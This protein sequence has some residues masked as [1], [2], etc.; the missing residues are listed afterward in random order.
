[1]KRNKCWFLAWM[2]AFALLISGFSPMGAEAAKKDGSKAD[3]V[4]DVTEYGAEANAGTDSAPAIEKAVKAAKEASDKG[5]SVVINFPKGRYDI[6]PDKIKERELYVSNTVG[7]EQAYSKKKIGILLEKMNNVTVEGNGSLFMYH[8]KMTTFAAINCKNVTFQNFAVDFQTPTVVDVT[9]EKREGNSV[10]VYVPE[11]YNYEI[12]GNNVKWISDKSPY[13]G[14]PYWTDTGKMDYTQRFDTKTGLTWR[15]DT[16]KNHLFDGS[17]SKIEDVGNHRLKFTFSGTPHEELQPGFCYQ[18]R[19]TKRDHPG[20]FLWKSTDVTLRHLDIQFLHGFGMVGQ[21]SDTI[22]LDDVDFEAPIESG[23]TTAGYADFVQMSGCKGE[24]DIHDCTF[25]NPHDDPINV[26]GTFNEVVEVKNGGKTFVVK[27]MHGETAGFPNFFEGDTVEFTTKGTLLPV[28]GSERKVESVKGPDGEGGYLEYDKA[29]NNEKNKAGYLKYIEITLDKPIDNITANNYVVEN[30]TYTPSVHIHDN[31]F[32]ETPTRGILVTTKQPVVIEDNT[33]DGMGMSGISISNDAQNW[34]ES[35]RTENVTI[36]NNVFTRGK[37]NAIYVCPTNPNGS[38]ETIHKNM[39]ITGNTF[40][41]EDKKVLNAKSVSDLEFTN[42]KIYRQEPNVTWKGEEKELS[43]KVGETKA[44]SLT[45]ESKAL[46]SKLYLFDGCHNVKVENNSYDAKVNAGS[47][48][49]NGTKESDIK[50][51]NDIMAINKDNKTEAGVVG[52]TTSDAKVAKASSSGIVSAVGEG[53][54][55]ITPY[56]LEGGRKF[57][58]TPVKVTVSKGEAAVL[59]DGI[60]ITAPTEKTGEETVKYEA[61][62]TGK[63][64]CSEEVSWSVLDPKTGQKTDRAEINTDGVL[65][66]KKSGA[67]EVVARTVNGLEARKLLSIQIGTLERADGF[68]V[69]N[70]NKDKWSIKGEDQ[71]TIQTQQQGLWN[72]QN[73]TNLFVGSLGKDGDVTATIK[74][75][76]KTVKDYDEAGLIFYKDNDNYVTVERKH[77]G[78][79]PQIKVVNEVNKAPNE[80]NDGGKK[81]SDAD[82]LYL[83]LEKKGN[84][85]TG[86]FSPDNSKWTKVREV[87][88]TNLGSDFQIGFLTGGTNSDTPFTF[89]ELTVNGKEVKL[90]GMSTDSLPKAK[91]AKLTYSAEENHLKASYELEGTKTAIVKWAAANEQ[92]GNYSVLEGLTGDEMFASKEL[93]GK[94]VKAAIV[95]VKDSGVSGDIVWTDGTLMTGEGTDGSNVKSANA[96]LA[97][98]EISGLKT[99]FEKFD[100]KTYHYYTTA[101]SS[102]KNVKAAFE[103]EDKNAKVKVWFNGKAID[104]TSGT[105]NLT[106]A[107]NL[108]EVQVTAEDGITVSNYRFTVSRTGEAV[109]GLKSLSVNGDDIKLVKDQFQYTYGMKKGNTVTV[110]AVPEPESAKV[111]ITCDGKEAGEDGKL[112]VKPGKSEVRIMVIP[113]TSAAPLVYTVSVKTPKSDN[114]NLEALMFSDNVQLNEKFETD[115]YNYTGLASEPNTSIRAVAEESNAKVSVFHEKEE[116]GKGTGSVYTATV[117]KEGKNELT[118]KVTSPDGKEKKEYKISLKGTGDMYLSDMNWDSEESGDPTS[119]PTRKDKSCGG[120]KIT[121]LDKNKEKKEF[122]KGVG[123]HADSTIIYDIAGKGYKTFES[124]IG[125]DQEIEKRDEPDVIFQVYMDEQKVYESKTMK[126]DT[127]MEH[128]SILV[129]ADAKKLKLVMDKVDNTWS[130]HGDWADA[131]LLRPFESTATVKLEVKTND[132]SMGTA[133]MDK[134]DGVYGKN[135]L[136]KLTAKAND[137]YQFVSWTDADGVVLSEDKSYSHVADEDEVITA[138]FKKKDATDPEDPNRPGGGDGDSGNQGSGD[139]QNQQSQDSVK[140]GDTVMIGLWVLLLALTTALIVMI[141]RRKRSMRR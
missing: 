109:V 15:G 141:V 115:V 85:V 96:Y 37:D 26:H 60:E 103:A 110:K 79:D 42:N 108:I 1:M 129:P 34:R 54:A 47:E 105:M 18:M 102:E 113:E 88:N 72:T 87:T 14:K 6:Y 66:P 117:L 81:T 77:G 50:L 132:P 121:L 8:G 39:T 49:K 134:E 75:D 23:R 22:T 63:S 4:I 62:V 95:P 119:N 36:K 124:Y 90:T 53:E 65:T 33:F 51:T 127:P 19:R 9:V 11:C 56:L 24:I 130:D 91:N 3:V 135:T 61:K 48:L 68:E 45:A 69:I 73:P 13:D 80:D 41:M 104:G 100:P 101:A 92:D 93:K 84:K 38:Q 94:Y 10:T 131:K 58:G 21:H 123:S 67:V 59:P 120:N 126:A 107:R 137:G 57:P 25:S 106:S 97:K 116:I 55:E 128:I 76:G 133:S 20:T 40:Y 86:S 140:T 99:A 78:N 46:N 29:P 31:V 2:M 98:A 118:V 70:E 138:N 5:K 83:K 64:G 89:S 74:M 139:G 16:G 44:L 27:Y 17:A 7:T 35:G 28:E 71:I 32:K 82:S 122:D 136:A 111:K 30:I 112:S 114:A 125:I 12:T 43:L 52:Y